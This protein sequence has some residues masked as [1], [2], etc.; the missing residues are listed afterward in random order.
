MHPGT[1]RSSSR[2]RNSAS[3][4]AGAYRPFILNLSG[5]IFWSGIGAISDMR[6]SPAAIEFSLV[7]YAPNDILCHAAN[8][9]TQC[10]GCGFAPGTVESLDFD[11]ELGYGDGYP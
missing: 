2:F 1:T 3:W 10:P 9:A 5:L 4:S 11:W 8:S 7:T 6:M